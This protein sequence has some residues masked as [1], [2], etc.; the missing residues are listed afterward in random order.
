M[1]DWATDS[2]VLLTESWAIIEA[3]NETSTD[4]F[5]RRPL[6]DTIDKWATPVWYV[7]GIPGNILAYSVWI[8]RRMRHSSGCYLAALALDECIFLG[9]QV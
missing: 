2:D 9:L 6:F 5:Y 4:F 1:S 7:I 8:Q 3:T